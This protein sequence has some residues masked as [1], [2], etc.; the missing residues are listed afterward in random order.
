MRVGHHLVDHALAADG[1]NDRCAPCSQEDKVDLSSQALVEHLLSRVPRHNYRFECDLALNLGRDHR[2]QVRFNL[3]YG[4][5][6]ENLR[7]FLGPDH[8]LQSQPC[9]MLRGQFRGKLDYKV[10]RLQK[11]DG[12]QNGAGDADA[13]S[14]A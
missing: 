14:V 3:V 7:A 13:P 4:A 1:C 9:M 5:V 10:A 11:A 2:D 12:A 8:M 6:G